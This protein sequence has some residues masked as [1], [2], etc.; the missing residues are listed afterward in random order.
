M[1]YLILTDESDIHQ[2]FL[3]SAKKRLSEK[4]FFAAK[5]RKEGSRT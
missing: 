3:M 2:D 5:R 4:S 1:P